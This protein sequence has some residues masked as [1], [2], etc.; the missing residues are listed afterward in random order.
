M[1]TTSKRGGFTLLPLGENIQANYAHFSKY[2]RP[3]SMPPTRGGITRVKANDSLTTTDQPTQFAGVARAVQLQQALE[4]AH[5]SHLAV[6]PQVAHSGHLA[7]LSEQVLLTAQA[8]PGRY[9]YPLQEGP[10]RPQ[11]NP[12]HEGPAYFDNGQIAEHSYM[13]AVWGTEGWSLA[14]ASQV[15]VPSGTFGRQLPPP[16]FQP[17]NPAQAAYQDTMHPGMG[18]PQA[19]LPPPPIFD[20]RP[21]LGAEAVN[22]PSTNPELLTSGPRQAPV[23]TTIPPHNQ[24]SSNITGVA[25]QHRVSQAPLM[26]IKVQHAS[27]I[28]QGAQAS[29]KGNPSSKTQGYRGDNNLHGNDPTTVSEAIKPM[30]VN[31]R[32]AQ[33]T[34]LP[35]PYDALQTGSPHGPTSKARSSGVLGPSSNDPP[36]PNAENPLSKQSE[37]EW[38]EK[39]YGT[40]IRHRPRQQVNRRLPSEW[41]REQPRSEDQPTN[42]A[43][44]SNNFGPESTMT[45]SRPTV[46]TVANISQPGPSALDRDGSVG[47]NKST[48]AT[49]T[50][51]NQAKNATNHSYLSSTIPPP[52]VVSTVF[53]ATSLATTGPSTG[54]PLKPQPADLET[55]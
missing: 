10:G 7:P 15:M 42:M 47:N 3:Q 29:G 30:K 25:A 32:Q 1:E 50:R 18:L 36:A 11:I 45:S 46:P 31:Q 13:V 44:H 20:L 41:M 26:T 48:S 19:Q 51:R 43:M 2:F 23:D 9:V 37:A 12:Y 49:G 53:S 39:N 5:L 35:K 24:P 4:P 8:P 6:Y 22:L 28:D 38:D 17:L 21:A 54:F 40:V 27:L 16:I 33:P 52:F 14:P 34:N 55:C